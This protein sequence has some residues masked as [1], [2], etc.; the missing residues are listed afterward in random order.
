MGM[1]D[2]RDYKAEAKALKYKRG[3]SD[4]ELSKLASRKK[5][6]ENN[7]MFIKRKGKMMSDRNKIKA[8]AFDYIMQ[9]QLLPSNNFTDI[10]NNAVTDIEDLDKRIRL[11]K[12][13]KAE[14]KYKFKKTK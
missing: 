12:Q 7:K 2:A 3:L 4:R 10:L 1:E 6:S 5:Y 14:E 9:L 8:E 13:Q 11:L